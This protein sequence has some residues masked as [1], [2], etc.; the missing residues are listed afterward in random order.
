MK[1]IIYILAASFILLVV[2]CAS[3]SHKAIEVAK[4][5]SA[6]TEKPL[7]KITATK[8]IFK[9][10]NMADGIYTATIHKSGFKEQIVT[11]TIAQGEMTELIIELEK[12]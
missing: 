5:T 11:V 1:K 9:I 4:S 3:E 6:K 7:V 12:N 10:K 2:G 8:G